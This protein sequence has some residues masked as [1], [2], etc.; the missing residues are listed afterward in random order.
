[1]QS[2]TDV[3]GRLKENYSKTAEEPVSTVE[4]TFSGDLLSANAVE[5]EKSYGEMALMME[6]A[7]GI[8]AWGK[9]LTMRAAEAGIIRKEAVKAVGEVTVT[10]SGTVLAGTQFSTE[11]GQFFEVLETTVVKDSGTVQIRAVTA[12]TSGN[13]AAGEINKIP[14]SIAGITNVTNKEAT[15]DGYDEESDDNLRERYLLHVRTPGTS[16]NKFHYLEWANS[17]AGVGA[18]KVIPTWNGPGT[19]KVIIVDSNYTTASDTLVKNVAD[20][21]ETVRPVGAIVTVVAAKQKT[22]NVAADV[23]GNVD[24]SAFQEAVK[25]YFIDI[26]KKSI[27]K[28]DAYYVSMAKVGSLIMEEGRAEDY[29]ALMLNGAA[30]NVVLG[31]EEIAVLGGV[32]FT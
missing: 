4:G 22:I 10:G 13:V 15:H 8:T 32:N 26:E 27:Q 17:V 30:A 7:Y 21:I 31:N 1:M 20:Y 29:T 2:Q 23:T 16:G 19:V 11:E 3:L 28:A 6:A 24:L 5:F 9:Y 18:A 12:G 25:A 14:M